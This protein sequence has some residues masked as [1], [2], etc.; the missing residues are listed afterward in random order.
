MI[1]NPDLQEARSKELEELGYREL[2][3]RILNCGTKNFYLGYPHTTLCKQRMCPTCAG[4]IAE[5]NSAHVQMAIRQFDNSVAF[6]VSV[7][8]MY[9]LARAITLFRDSLLK[10][11]HRVEFKS[12]VPGGVSALEVKYD[13]TTGFWLVHAHLILDDQGI[14]TDF[15]KESWGKYTRISGT[16]WTGR[17]EY[18]TDP[19]VDLRRLKQLA[20]YI[21]KKET[22]CPTPTEPTPDSLRKLNEIIMAIKHRKLLIA[23]GTGRLIGQE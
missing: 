15:L 2:A 22:W 14:D 5:R 6:L 7:S 9:D 10:I 1:F 13:E 3:G 18:H 17:F 4:I 20:D 16:N 11:R 21:T 19:Q 12:H 23:W 8:K